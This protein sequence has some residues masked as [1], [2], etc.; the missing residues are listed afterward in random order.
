MI[1]C[2]TCINHDAVIGALHDIWHEMEEF[3]THWLTYQIAA[4]EYR[5]QDYMKAWHSIR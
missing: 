4:R 1:H 3:N 2:A 5:C